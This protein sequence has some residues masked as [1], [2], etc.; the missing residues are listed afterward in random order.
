[1]DIFAALPESDSG[2]VSLED[3]YSYLQQRGYPP[4]GEHI[5]IEGVSVQVLVPSTSLQTEALD[6]ATG[7]T[8][9]TETVRVMSAE[10]LLAIMA[11]LNR[12]KDRIRISLFL[13][14]FDVDNE[15]LA[16]ILARHGLE[17]KW[18]KI[19]MELGLERP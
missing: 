5:V 19:L 18:K 2:L 3:I 16:V 6:N 7:R 15:K 10:H 11:E 4:D 13:E 1:M 14:Q 9:G 17:P 8:Y 12:P